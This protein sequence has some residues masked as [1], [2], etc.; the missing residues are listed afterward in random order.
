MSISLA[1]AKNLIRGKGLRAT[2][3]RISVLQLFAN[4]DK[5]LSHGNV[6]ELI[7]QSVGDQATLY[8]IL[9]KFKE[10]GILRVAS[11]AKGI[12]RY[13]LVDDTHNEEGQKHPHFVC[14]KCEFISCL[15]DITISF[16]K[17]S[18]WFKPLMLAEMQFIGVCEKC[19]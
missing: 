8:R 17:D 5:P 12:N 10:A 13:E 2:Q 19:A 3:A 18:P 11:T 15:P 14:E 6:V 9:I 4:Y 1:E 7:N 16:E